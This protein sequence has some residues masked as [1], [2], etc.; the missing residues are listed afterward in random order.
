MQRRRVEER[1]IIL[2]S[3]PEC[4]RPAVP[5]T[6]IHTQAPVLL[7]CSDRSS[8]LFALHP[9]F[10]SSC[11][12]FVF[13][14]CCLAARLFRGT[15]RCQSRTTSPRRFRRARA[16]RPLTLLRPCRSQFVLRRTTSTR[17]PSNRRAFTCRC[18]ALFVR[19]CFH[20]R[21]FC[22]HICLLA[23]G[24]TVVDAHARIERARPTELAPPAP[25][26]MPNGSTT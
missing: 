11:I 24:V 1:R 7:G 8:G 22:G 15:R 26:V 21:S 4:A 25:A 16:C 12:R 13:R 19:F 20:A 17:M 9:V 10:V 3:N 18:P 23:D 2:F 14:T 5:L 6:T